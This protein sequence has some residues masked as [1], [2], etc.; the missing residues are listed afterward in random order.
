M[1]DIGDSLIFLGIFAVGG[2]AYMW[3]GFSVLLVVITPMNYRYIKYSPETLVPLV[4]CILNTSIT[5]AI[6]SSHL[7]AEVG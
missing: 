1:V 5:E 6:C 7:V 2:V 4:T 3:M